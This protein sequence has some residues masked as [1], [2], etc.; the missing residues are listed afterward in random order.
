MEQ[1]PEKNISTKIYPINKEVVAL[2]LFFVFCAAIAA[3]LNFFPAYFWLTAIP[4]ALLLLFFLARHPFY[5]FLLFIIS[6]PFEAAFVFEI[7]FTVRISYILLAAVIVSLIISKQKLRV[8]SAL[9][10]PILVFLAVAVLSLLVNI[11]FPP[12]LTNLSEAMKYRGG[13]FRPLV[14]LLFLFFFA[15]SYF[16]TIHFCSNI[17]KLGKVLKTY[18]L[19]AA[20]AACYG[21]YQFFALIFHLPFV[22]ITNAIA[23]SGIGRGASFYVDP[24]LFRVHSVFQ[25][26][27]CFA[28]YILSVF[29]LLL[30]LFIFRSR[31]DIKNDSNLKIRPGLLAI[32]IFSAALLLTKSRGAWVGLAFSFLAI[33]FAAKTSIKLKLIFIGIIAA[34]F[35][36]LL[37]FTPILGQSEMNFGNYI[38]DRFSPQ[39]LRDEPRLADLNFAMDL[40]TRFPVLGVGMGN[41]GFYAANYY[42]AQMLPIAPNI[43][44]QALAETGII[45]L[46][47]LFFLM[48]SYCVVMIKA[49]KE[50]M[51]TS[52]YP[53]LL[54]VWACFAAMMGQY[55][56]S[57][58]RLPLYFWVFMGISM[59]A[60]KLIGKAANNH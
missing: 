14:Q 36:F 28:N 24:F 3:T 46:D 32:L 17:K 33:F 22:D 55:F 9:N 11:F 23:T 6:L 49:L 42:N 27:L 38:A 60:V 31:N 18:I 48:L 39:V 16:I 1:L 10:I 25:E 5:S 50:N 51:C 19:T 30:T 21:I 43:W 45:G 26:P 7:G 37:T 54:G 15:L 47:A 41:Y 2:S 56:F 53:Y 52:W 44:M 29:P 12:P 8:K 35:L 57:L 4:L 59:A 13:E 34:L 58:D 40:W 20:A